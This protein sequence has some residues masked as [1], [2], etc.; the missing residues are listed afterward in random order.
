ME[1]KVCTLRVIAGQVLP[2]IG[3]TISFN[4]K[5]MRVIHVDNNSVLA[6]FI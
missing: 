1:K 6:V 5:M 4:G 2:I 3:E